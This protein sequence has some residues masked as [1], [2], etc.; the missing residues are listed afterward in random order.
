MLV[1]WIAAALQEAR[2]SF[3]RLRGYRDL[4][5]LIRTLDRRTVDTVK[6]VA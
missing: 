5:A 2:Q 1:R 3:R 6:E 4:A